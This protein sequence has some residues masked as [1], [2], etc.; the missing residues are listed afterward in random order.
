[1][2]TSGKLIF[3]C[4]KMAAGKSTFA[5]KL[6]LAERAL[7]LVQDDLL[8][9]LFPDEIT[10][11]PSFVNRYTKLKKALTPHICDL[12]SKGNTLV[13]D[14]AAATK[15]QRVWFRE[16]IERTQV[17]HE[18]HFLDVPDAVCVMQLQN[19]SRGL[20]H[21]SPWT[22]VEEFQAINVYFEPPSEDEEF[23]VL[24]HERG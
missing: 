8:N 24:R 22:T 12:L 17:E 13:L 6:A 7:L 15:S 5:R 10:D 1:M 11:I 2:N 18:L 4:G 14:F 9:A 16:L 3:L 20:P 21:G 19:R 23:I